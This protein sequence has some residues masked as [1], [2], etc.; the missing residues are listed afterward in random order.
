VE[1]QQQG[2][3]CCYSSKGIAEGQWQQQQQQQLWFLSAALLSDV[4]PVNT[5]Q[6]KGMQSA[7]SSSFL[8]SPGLLMLHQPTHMSATCQQFHVHHMCQFMQLD[9]LTGGK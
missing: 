6:G 5:Q 7:V 4:Q 3:P 9:C 1:L 8:Y 2:Q